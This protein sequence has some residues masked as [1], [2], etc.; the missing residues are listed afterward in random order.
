[1]IVALLDHLWQST[2]F[3]AMAGLATLLFRANGAGVRYGLWL[4]ASMKFLIP[5]ALL[6][7]VGRSL[8]VSGKPAI[9]WPP[10]LCDLQPA[11]QP[12]SFVPPVV[13]AVAPSGS[14]IAPVLIG[15]WA[16][17]FVTVLAM[18]MVRWSLLQ[19]GLRKAKEANIA[20][21]LPVK[22]STGILAPGLVGIWRPVLVLPEGIATRL[23][24]AE[25]QSVVMHEICHLRRRDNLTASLHMIVEAVFWFHPLVWWL[26]SRLIEEREC[27]CDE[28]VLKA[29]ADPE[30]Y[31]QGILKVCQLYLRLPLDAVSGVSGADLKKRIEI[32]MENRFV[33]RL[34]VGKKALLGMAAIVTLTLPIVLGIIG[35]LSASAQSPIVQAPDKS[36][37]KLGGRIMPRTAISIDS[38]RFDKYAGYY[39]LPD[40]A[41]LHVIRDGSR[42]FV[43]KAAQQPVQ[44]FPESAVKFFLETTAPAQISF[45]INMAGVVTGA[46]L[47]QG[48]QEYPARRIEEAQAKA[49]E[50]GFAQRPRKN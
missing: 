45:E 1:M 27:A 2:L 22:Y 4:A 36:S 13:T 19:N 10:L 35:A 47:H 6:S 14:Q 44:I 37:G 48:A 28:N 30:T 5:F 43:Q 33:A 16:L 38:T 8:V 11:A 12:F 7:F 23:S 21:D 26:G 24:P 50:I 29:G 25:L 46:V 39:Q 17:G 49:S 20:A 15:L 42:Y 41:I 40:G 18:W 31:A 32:I 34:N 3:A 9:G